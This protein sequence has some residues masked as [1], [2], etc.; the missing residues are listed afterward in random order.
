MLA[1]FLLKN[2]FYLYFSPI[3]K[4]WSRKS[5]KFSFFKLLQNHKVSEHPFKQNRSMLKIWL[6]YNYFFNISLNAI[7]PTFFNIC[8]LPFLRSL[9]ICKIRVKVGP[10]TNYFSYF[11]SSCTNRIAVF[12]NSFSLIYSQPRNKQNR[13]LDFFS[14]W[15]FLNNQFLNCFYGKY[16]FKTRQIIAIKMNNSL[17]DKTRGRF[18]AAFC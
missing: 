4:L 11:M 12:S 8:N 1:L 2:I 3:A 16:A 13:A 9:N 10:K 18:C 7:R 5:R 17:S 6:C 14:F 15:I